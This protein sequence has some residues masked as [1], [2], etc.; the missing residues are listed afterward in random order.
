MKLSKININMLL[1]VL[2]LALT[3]G[4]DDNG[5]SPNLNMQ[6]MNVGVFASKITHI[7]PNTERVDTII[8]RIRGSIRGN[9][10]PEF[11]YLKFQDSISYPHYYFQGK[12]HFGYERESNEYANFLGRFDIVEIELKT[13]QGV[14]SG[15]I[16]IPDTLENLVLSEYDSLG[17]GESFEL[18]WS[19]S[20]A[21]FYSVEVFYMTQN[22]SNIYD[23]LVNSNRVKFNASYFKNPGEINSVRVTPVN[24]IFPAKGAQGNIT[25]D[26]TGYLYYQN[27]IGDQG[28]YRDDIKVGS[29]FSKSFDKKQF[30]KEKYMSNKSLLERIN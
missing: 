30:L 6:S 20:D 27:S 8:N 13:S 5:S 25:G 28:V 16:S 9:P 4:C 29:G 2:L 19:G 12:L 10:L 22:F 7:K 21:D 3:S 1:F 11:H 26:G 24:G 14:M 15:E 23:T 18:S 17:I